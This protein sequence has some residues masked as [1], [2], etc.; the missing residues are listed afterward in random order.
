MHE[1]LVF[2]EGVASSF[3]TFGISTQPFKT[4]N[5]RINKKPTLRVANIF[6]ELEIDYII[7]FKLCLFIVSRKPHPKFIQCRCDP[8]S[9]LEKLSHYLTSNIHNFQH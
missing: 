6:C 7:H 2:L 1:L 4:S 8:A 3:S 9:N 5:L